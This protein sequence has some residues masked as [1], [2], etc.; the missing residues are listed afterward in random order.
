MHFSC[1]LSLP[2]F[3]YAFVI[4]VGLV[5]FINLILFILI[6][7]SITCDRSKGMRN[8]QRDR[9]LTMLQA[10]A[11]ICCLVVM[12]EELLPLYNVCQCADDPP[13]P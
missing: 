2:A 1:W 3:Y 12:G 6:I 10:R 8:T 5:I 9:D 13:E 11:A 7:K 4:P